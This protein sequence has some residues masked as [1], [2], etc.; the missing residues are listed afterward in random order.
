MEGRVSPSEASVAYQ[1]QGLGP[2]KDVK[3]GPVIEP[4][5]MSSSASPGTNEIK[6]WQE[7]F[8][9][10]KAPV[11]LARGTRDV[12]MF[13]GL[14]AVVGIGMVYTFY[15][16]YLMSTGQLKKKER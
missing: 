13:R 3:T 9:K 12:I 16:M 7:I 2:L 14:S 15:N 4:P 5:N 11:Y 10:T 6:K 1:P 8:Q